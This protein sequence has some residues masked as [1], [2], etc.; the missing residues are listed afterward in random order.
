MTRIC[1][2]LHNLIIL[3][4]HN[5]GLCL[6]GSCLTKH[7]CWNFERH[8]GLVL[9][10]GI[11]LSSCQQSWCSFFKRRRVL[12]WMNVP[13]TIWYTGWW[14]QKLV[15]L[16]HST[17]KLL[18][19]FLRFRR[20]FTGSWFL[21]R[22]ALLKFYEAY[23]LPTSDYC[24]VCVV[25]LHN[26]SSLENYRVYK[27]TLNEWPSRSLASPLPQASARS[28]DGTHYKHAGIPTWPHKST[29]YHSRAMRGN[30]LLL[31][32]HRLPHAHTSQ[33]SPMSKV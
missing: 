25:L 19:T 32:P 6:I 7:F 3:P 2:C 17:L 26:D 5:R 14:T 10:I 1:L 33:W 11:D 21:P 27:T 20:T 16:Q 13:L 22:S 4:V 9:I 30:L 8:I 12:S 29:G 18:G 23:I 31:Q 15:G 24:D 28:S